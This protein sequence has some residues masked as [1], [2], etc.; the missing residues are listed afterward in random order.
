MYIIQT[1]C[2]IPRYTN[3]TIN[4]S[5]LIV[6]HCAV[7]LVLYLNMKRDTEYTLY[8]IDAY[9]H[10]AGVEQKVKVTSFSIIP[11]SGDPCQVKMGATYTGNVSIVPG[12]D[13]V[14]CILEIIE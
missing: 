6:R 10:A 1:H 7:V 2:V 8:A 13:V 4:L 14:I 5:R 9:V 3:S 12:A 11:C